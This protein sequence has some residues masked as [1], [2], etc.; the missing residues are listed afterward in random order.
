MIG[1]IHTLTT[2]SAYLKKLFERLEAK[3]QVRCRDCKWWV[4]KMQYGDVMGGCSHPRMNTNAPD[5]T[6]WPEDGLWVDE[7]AFMTGP[8]FG[9]I[10]AESK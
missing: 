3:P 2:E 10:H 5:T 6:E 7:N 8:L 1:D 4:R 9:C